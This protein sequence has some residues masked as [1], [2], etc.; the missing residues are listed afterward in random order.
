M[1]GRFGVGK[2]LG[3]AAGGDGAVPHRP[4]RTVDTGRTRVVQG[5]V[6]GLL[7]ER[8]GMHTL[9]RSGDCFV[10]DRPAVRRQ[11]VVQHVANE[12]VGELVALGGEAAHQSGGERLVEGVGEGIRG[13][14][15]DLPDDPWI[16]HHAGNR[17]GAEQLLGRQRQRALALEHDVTDIGRDGD[18]NRSR[19]GRPAVR[20][21]LD[22][23]VVEQAGEQLADIE[24]VATALPPHG[25][26]EGSHG[27][28]QGLLTQHSTEGVED[29]VL[30]E[31][32]EHDRHDRNSSTQC[33]E[34]VA[35]RVG[36]LL[37]S[38]GPDTEQRNPGEP[39]RDVVQHRQRWRGRPS[40]VVDDDE[41]GVFPSQEV[42]PLGDRFEEVVALSVAVGRFRIAEVG[43]LIAD[44]R[45]EP[46]QFSGLLGG[47]Q[48]ELL[49]VTDEALQRLDNGLVGVRH[50]LV[51]ACRTGRCH[52]RPWCVW[53][54]RCRA[55]SCRHPARRRPSPADRLPGGHSSTSS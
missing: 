28:L 52:R 10:D 31:P 54:V 36:S 46:G 29:V 47:K 53:P 19:G 25:A 42:K 35:Q 55:G 24:R 6:I 37:R 38:V 39:G 27:R 32:T 48:F 40:Q 49:G 23:S 34:D 5:E 45:N 16:E 50:Q 12:S 3:C 20:A 2:S 18:L 7:V 8:T 17:G 44:R 4:R 41:D 9:D 51:A 21:P 14:L 22:R 26:T 43:Q 15:D 13:Q 30:A 1:G 33:C 11:F